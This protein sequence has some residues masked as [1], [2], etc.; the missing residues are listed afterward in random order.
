M[1]PHTH[2]DQLWS[3]GQT[4]SI[5]EPQ[6]IIISKDVQQG[7]V[8]VYSYYNLNKSLLT[9]QEMLNF[10]AKIPLIQ[11]TKEKLK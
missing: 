9:K 1:F 5:Q 6:L 7:S 2:L 3:R 8:Y 4:A 11:K 10:E